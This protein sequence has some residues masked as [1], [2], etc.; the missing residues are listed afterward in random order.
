MAFKDV[1]VPLLS[2]AEDEGALRAAE[3]VADL[4]DARVSAVFLE[5]EPD[6]IPTVDGYISGGL[7]EDIIGQIAAD[8][9]KARAALAA[10][11]SSRRTAFTELRSTLSLVGG[12]LGA[13][14]RC[15]DLVVMTRPVQGVW[16]DSIRAAVFE[17]VLFESG[18][19]VLLTPQDWR[20][21]VGRNITIAWNGKRE[22][23][24][25]VADAL[26]LLEE[27]DKVTIVSVAQR[28]EDCPRSAATLTAHLLRHGI[29]ADERVVLA[30]HG[31]ESASLIA[32][33]LERG[34]DLIVMGGYGHA[35]AA[36]WMFGGVTRALSKSAPLPVFMSH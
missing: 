23:A 7:W 3:I 1:L 21:T 33:V 14:A 29:R 10:R 24:R 31:D 12:D 30:P 5:V 4:V 25:A 9:R 28:A 15:T 32:D 36:E 2:V 19:P 20:G 22:A 8:A 6:S 35:R 18:R 34:S 17:G 11:P 13:L 26:P 27:A 16:S